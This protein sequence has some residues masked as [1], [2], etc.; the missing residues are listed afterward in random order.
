MAVIGIGLIVG[1]VRGRAWLMI[2]VGLLL[3][4]LLGVA[5]ALPRN[6]TW[7]AGSRT[8]TPTSA[9][10]SSPY[11]LG[12]GDATLD[13]SQVGAGQTAT[14]VGRIGAGRLTVLVPRDSSVSVDARMSA[15]RISLF[16]H[17]EDGTGL[18]NR[19]TV[20]RARPGA[21]TLTLDLQ[22]GY[23]DMEVRYAPA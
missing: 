2:P 19:W 15:G 12:A 11:V 13:L 20:T 3:V 5:D 1:A 18:D 6:L 8:W 14:I 22:G 23:G 10:V 21:G 9:T 7:T 16:G 17:E 4:A